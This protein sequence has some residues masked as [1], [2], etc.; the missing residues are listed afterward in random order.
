MGL[1]GLS[2]AVLGR[3]QRALDGPWGALG[4]QLGPSSGPGPAQPRPGPAQGWAQPR[5]KPGRQRRQEY[6]V[7]KRKRKAGQEETRQEHTGQNAT[8]QEELQFSEVTQGLSRRPVPQPLHPSL[9][10]EFW[11]AWWDH[12]PG[13]FGSTPRRVSLGLGGRSWAAFGC[14]LLPAGPS[15]NF[16]PGQ[17]AAE[18]QTSHFRG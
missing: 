17:V 8:R 14:C 15:W 1:L 9:V 10:Q 2:W 4:T 6:R 7:R 18:R 3:S 12:L 13:I 16:L 5:P 11:D